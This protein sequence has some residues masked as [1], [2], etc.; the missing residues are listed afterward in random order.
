MRDQAPVKT[1]I[2][3]EE[4]KSA[5]TLLKAGQLV[6]FPT[7]TVYG[8]GCDAANVEAL[9]RLYRVKGRPGNHPVIVHLASVE[10]LK[11]WAKTVPPEALALAKKFWP[12]PMTLIL[13]KSDKVL[14]EVSG[15]QDTV[16][17]RI[18]SHPVA[19]ALLKEFNSGV[20]APSANKHG[21]ISPTTAEHVKSELGD[22]VA[23]VL[24]GGNCSV[25]IES[26]IVDLS[27]EKPRILRPGMI[28][29]QEIENVLKEAREEAKDDSKRKAKSAKSK[30]SKSADSQTG[31]D[32]N[33][34][35]VPRAPGTL[36]SHYAP[37]TDLKLFTHANLPRAIATSESLMMKVSVMAFS[38]P[39]KATS[40]IAWK[41]MSEDPAE[42]ARQLYA[43]MRELDTSGADYIVVEEPPEL[44]EWMGILDRLRRAANG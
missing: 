17:L 28:T 18:P 26:T 19:L 30:Q 31:G 23:K 36:S 40:V 8:L 1:A 6:A 25:G 5:S 29:L 10:Q 11:D 39:I 35:V 2:N 42:C 15:G 7:E 43:F 21:R 32:S 33:S 13:K 38:D 14:P 27:S 44:P 22:L 9:A 37:T 41:Q 16:G 20:A 3:A 34:T 12:G 4:I 24:D